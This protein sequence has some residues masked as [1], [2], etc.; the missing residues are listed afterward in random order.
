M[1]FYGVVFSDCG[2]L[3]PDTIL[4]AMLLEVTASGFGDET[5]TNNLH[6]FRSTHFNPED[7]RK[8]CLRNVC[9]QLHDNTASQPGRSQFDIR[10][11][12]FLGWLH[13]Q[14]P[15]CTLFVSNMGEKKKLAYKG[16]NSRWR[17]RISV[18]QQ[19]SI[20]LN[21]LLNSVCGMLLTTTSSIIIFSLSVYK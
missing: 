8:K 7:W 16:N 4:Y 13:L 10:I 19:L 21:V 2:Y 17:S 12:K 6:T 11:K 20:Q 15:S 9:F 5:S 1:F 14:C 18:K 3:C